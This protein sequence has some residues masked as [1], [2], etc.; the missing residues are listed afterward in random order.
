[1][2]K[3]NNS[4]S[5]VKDTMIL[6]FY[7][8]NNILGFT[9]DDYMNA[10]IALFNGHSIIIDETSDIVADLFKRL[11]TVN[12]PVVVIG[13]NDKLTQPTKNLKLASTKIIWTNFGT[14]FAN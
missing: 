2:F 11:A 3:M 13:E 4:V 7:D 5:V 1:M 12:I 6:C 14:K 8:E 10:L 9:S